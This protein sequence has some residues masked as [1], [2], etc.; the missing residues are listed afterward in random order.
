MT[1]KAAEVIQKLKE[2]WADVPSLIEATGWKPNTLRAAISTES[3]KLGVK[4]ER[5]REG[6]V[7]SYRAVNYVG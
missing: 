4:I 1:E 2:G 3:R 6:G 5:R 7:T